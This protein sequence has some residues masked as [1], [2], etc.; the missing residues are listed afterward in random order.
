MSHKGQ[1]PQTVSLAEWDDGTFS[2]GWITMTRSQVRAFGEQ[3]I[4]I[5]DGTE[6][7]KAEPLSPRK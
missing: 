3:L 5:A 2:I 6:E 7:T 1:K 4:R